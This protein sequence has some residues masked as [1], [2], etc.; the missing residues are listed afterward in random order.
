[1]P[2]ETLVADFFGRLDRAKEKM[3][4]VSQFKKFKYVESP[5]ITLFEKLY[6]DI[7]TFVG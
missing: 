2:M 1:M 5:S 4:Q 3:E 6:Q 7:E